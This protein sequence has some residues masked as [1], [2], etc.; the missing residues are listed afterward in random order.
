MTLKEALESGKRFWRTSNP[1]EIYSRDSIGK[2]HYCQESVLA[3]DWEIEEKRV[4]VSAEQL[5]KLGKDWICDSEVMSLTN[6][7][8]KELGLEE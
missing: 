3:T 6:Y 4:E 8:I 1:E 7:L 5:R 2:T